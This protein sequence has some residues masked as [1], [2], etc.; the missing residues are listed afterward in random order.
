MNK[1][2]AGFAGHAL[3]LAGFL[4]AFAACVV[5][6]LYQAGT[7]P[8][9][10]QRYTVS[11]QVPTANF[12][13]AGARV[14]V[15]GAEVGQV[16]SVDRAGS[17]SQDAT[18]RMDITDPGVFPLP[19]D[20][21]VQIR[22][23]SQVGENYVNIVVGD[24]RVSVPDNGSLG[25]DHADEFVGID[26][27][28]SVL[29]GKTKAR[30]R[31]LLQRLD[32]GLSGRG[33]ALHR[34]LSPAAD[35]IDYGT[36]AVTAIAPD[37]RELGRLVD[38]LGHLTAAIGDRSTAIDT[39]A[40]QGTASLQA[41]AS[42]DEQVAATLR[43]LPATIDQIRRTTGVIGD[44]STRAT[45][46][47]ANLARATRDLKPAVDALAPAARDGRSIVRRLD[48]AVPELQSL[49]KA[50]PSLTGYPAAKGGAPRGLL[51][52]TTPLRQTLCE[53]NPAL[54][55]LEPYIPDL[56]SIVTHL[57]SV[58]NAYDA[59]GHLVRMTPIISEN[60]LAGAPPQLEGPIQ[61]LISSGLLIPQKGM[62]YQAYTKPGDVGRIAAKRGDPTT[63]D[64]YS[65]TVKYTRVEADC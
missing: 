25:L 55:Y 65:K 29:R 19:S 59:T 48:D 46:V 31:T 22:T 10:G 14:T 9:L 51:A 42:R 24:S 63:P 56:Y 47:V 27:I 41:I 13:A 18:I 12:L 39:V 58:S 7:I 57:S 8:H 15:A 34:T 53:A 37:R 20:S 11:A 49:L 60:S 44:V 54:R 16:K 23:R 2:R 3:I 32:A 38:Q 30:T 43:Q 52:A 17:L 4:A 40:R 62:A 61:T 64:A 28:L 6:M 50:V 26:Q 35:A 36:Q 33:P 5:F 45:P 1:G 21:R